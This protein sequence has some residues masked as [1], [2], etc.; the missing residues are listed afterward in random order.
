LNRH[1]EPH[2]RDDRRRDRTRRRLIG[3]DEIPEQLV[4]RWLAAWETDNT[5][6]PWDYARDWV[7][8]QVLAGRNPPGSRE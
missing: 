1:P 7:V 5:H 8:G 3:A 2:V 4:D 6:V